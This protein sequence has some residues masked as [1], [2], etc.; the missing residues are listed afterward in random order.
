M[1]E[2]VG[3]SASPGIARGRAFLFI[4]DKPTIPHYEIPASQVDHEN[5]RF[6]T[7]LRQAS[8]EVKALAKGREAKLFEAQILMFDDPDLKSRVRTALQEARSNVEWVLVQIIEEMSGKLA[9][10]DSQYLRER[11]IDFSDA[12]TRILGHLLYR[13]KA[14][15]SDVR[16]QV[17]L[18]TH[19]LMPS[20]T[21]GLDPTLVLGIAADV[22]GKTSHTAIL[23]RSSEIPAVL[24]LSDISRHVKNGDEVIVDG[25]AGAVIVNPDDATRARYE[26]RK[27]EWARKYAILKEL[28][29]LPAET[30]DGK[31]VSIEA[32]IETPDEVD[33]VLTH[34]GDGIGLFRSEFLFLQPNRFPTEEDQYQAYSSVLKAMRGKSVTIRTLDLGG[35]KVMPGISLETDANPLL[36]WRAVRFCLSR[37]ELFRLQLR[38]LLR[39]SVHGSLRI[40]FPLISGAEELARINTM[41]GEV[42]EELRREK[43]S[44]REDI[45][46]GIMIEVPSA[47]M[48]SDILAARAD[49]FSI[50]TND[51]IQYSLAVDRGNQ[52][53]AYLYEPFHP[54]VLRLVRMT[55]EN[56]HARGIPVGM[57]GEMAGD[58]L[59]TIVLLGLGLDSFSMGPIGIPLIKRIIRSVGVMEVE[60]FVRGLIPMSSGAEIETAVRRWMEERLGFSSW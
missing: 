48:T 1:M 34:G 44:F 29:E 50:G 42:R 32:N 8:D 57:C 5:E 14:R 43:V 28:R 25:T 30:M 56:A 33:S 11:T 24:G 35:D 19:N 37:P 22:G 49:F 18:V 6:L 45:P 21:L 54:G 17:I 47:A 55:I 20:D 9:A 36:G 31:L 58:P 52:R 13:P 4:E 12:G 51:L 10:S 59:A 41:L 27:R 40:M 2:F 53:V 46:I 16:E 23:A 7:A 39:S 60:A 3:I 15:L 38:A 26:E